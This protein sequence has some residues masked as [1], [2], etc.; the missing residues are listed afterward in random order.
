VGSAAVPGRVI[1]HRRQVA[2]QGTDIVK[3]GL[4]DRCFLLLDGRPF[5][6]KL[7]WCHQYSP[8]DMVWQDELPNV[9]GNDHQA[10]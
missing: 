2:Y 8:F 5:G 7:L 3:M 4:G 6:D 10:K 9:T 1:F